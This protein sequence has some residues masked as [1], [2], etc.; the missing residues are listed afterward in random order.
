MPS[1]NRL[2]SVPP[3]PR[4]ADTSLNADDDARRY[5]CTGAIAHETNARTE[6]ER[7]NQHTP[8]R[9][10][11]LKSVVLTP[12]GV[13]EGIRMGGDLLRFDPVSGYSGVRSPSG[14]IRT[15]FRPDEGIDYFLRQFL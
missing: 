12:S 3:R 1:E 15:F 10:K 7:Q 13:L 6:T 11:D 4:G 9:H 2:T 14:L 5:P 8:A